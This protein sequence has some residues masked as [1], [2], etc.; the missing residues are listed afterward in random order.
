MRS[1]LMPGDGLVDEM[2]HLRSAVRRPHAHQL[3]WY[4]P[5]LWPA[6]PRPGTSNPQFVAGCV[7]YRS[8]LRPLPR[9]R[10]PDA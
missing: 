5:G 8:V 1:E 9:H 7:G 6:P 3:C 10:R 4:H 2:L